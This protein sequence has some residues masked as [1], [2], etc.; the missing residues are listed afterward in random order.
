MPTL[1]NNKNNSNNNNN[2]T[3]AS[4][5]QVPLPPQPSPLTAFYLRSE[6]LS[7]LQTISAAVSSMRALQLLVR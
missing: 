7:R 5:S 3:T 2:T 4:A 1:Y 6:V